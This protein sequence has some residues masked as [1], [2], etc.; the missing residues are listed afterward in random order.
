MT[1]KRLKYLIALSFI[2]I[3]FVLSCQ[4][5]ETDKIPITTSSKEALSNYLKGRDSSERLKTDQ[6]INYFKKAITL[7]PNFA[8]AHLNLAF[9]LPNS[10]ET[11]AEL[12]KA[13]NLVDKV[14]E[15]EKL[16]ILGTQASVNGIT[17]KEREYFQKLV[18]NFPEDERAQYM[19]GIYYYRQQDYNIA[20]GFFRRATEINPD[21]S[22]A[23]NILGY[24]HRYL[25]NYSEAEEAFKKYIGLV[26][27]D[28]NPYDSYAELLLKM[29]RFEDSIKN[30]KK[31]LKLDP[32]FTASTIGIATNLNL[33]N[34][35]EEARSLLQESPASIQNDADYRHIMYA[36]TVSYVDEG[37]IQSGISEMKSLFNLDRKNEDSFNMGRDLGI[38]GDCYF[39]LMKYDSALYY[40][41]WVTKITRNSDLPDEIINLRNNTEKYQ[42]AKVALMEGD[43]ETAR[44]YAREYESKA[45]ELSNRFQIWSSHRLNGMIAMK[46]KDYD[47]ALAELSR[48]NQQD[49]YVL[50]QIGLTYRDKG[51]MLQA[52][53]FLTKAV[54]FNIVNSI[55]Y[56]FCR[57]KA[58]DILQRYF[59]D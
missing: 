41:N 27:T 1:S 37:N 16:Y 54:N 38:I 49:P 47:Q 33:L 24:T 22:V 13:V 59:S 44:E 29:G 57:K 56:A 28:P 7:D 10:K 26:P 48:A 36:I 18:E 58:E 8:M 31:A 46:E 3:L 4:N 30:Y 52:K 39:E 40:Y 42:I 51:D 12:N 34:K 5:K 53:K 25:G 19:M 9:L 20:L 21:F 6:A 45:N 11:F 32:H 23:Y 14:S 17:T 15:G 43:L 50:F 35:H 2:I 55:E